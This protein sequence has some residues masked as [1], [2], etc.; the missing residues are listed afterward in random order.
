MLRQL[1]V[2]VGIDEFTVLLKEVSSFQERQTWWPVSKLSFDYQFRSRSPEPICCCRLPD[3]LLLTL[4]FLLN[5]FACSLVAS[6][7][8]TKSLSRHFV[9]Q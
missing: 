1:G 6:S 5:N 2:K 7:R 4:S 8:T 3:A 9:K